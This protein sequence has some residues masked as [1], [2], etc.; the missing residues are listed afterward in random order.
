MARRTRWLKARPGRDAEI[1]EVCL[2]QRREDT[3]GRPLKTYSIEELQAMS[4]AQ[5]ASVKADGLLPHLI[6]PHGP[7]GWNKDGVIDCR[8]DACESARAAWRKLTG[9]D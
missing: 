6:L 8:C 3:F 7:V 5:F 1:V 9:R 4:P 2:R